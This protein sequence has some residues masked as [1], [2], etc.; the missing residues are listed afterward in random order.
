[1]VLIVLNDTVL[2]DKWGFI[3]LFKRYLEPE[4]VD[5]LLRGYYDGDTMTIHP[6][7]IEVRVE[8]LS[9][10]IPREIYEEV[11]KKW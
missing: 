8:S 4:Q 3:K 10:S 5:E 7:G 11:K 2:M 6:F 9:V 1:M